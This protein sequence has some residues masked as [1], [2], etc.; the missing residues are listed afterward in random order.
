MNFSLKPNIDSRVFTESALAE[1]VSCGFTSCPVQFEGV[2]TTDW[3][4]LLSI[5]LNKMSAVIHRLWQPW[6]ACYIF[7]TITCEAALKNAKK[8]KCP[9]QM[10]HMLFFSLRRFE[11]DLH[12]CQRGPPGSLRCPTERCRWCRSCPLTWRRGLSVRHPHGESP[13]VR[14]GVGFSDGQHFGQTGPKHSATKIDTNHQ[15]LLLAGVPV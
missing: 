1:H 13:L 7:H 12:L 14:N 9:E 3:I 15:A 5:A 11:C 6:T 2:F 4:G 8:K 10:L